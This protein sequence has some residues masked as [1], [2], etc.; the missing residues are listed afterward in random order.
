MMVV[1]NVYSFVQLYIIQILLPLDPKLTQNQTESQGRNY[2]TFTKDQNFGVQNFRLQV[3]RDGG[4]RSDITNSYPLG[5][6]PTIN[7]LPIDGKSKG[8]LPSF[9]SLSLSS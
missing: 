3:S 2:S 6:V 7:F 5:F 8:L 1:V 9:V 4:K